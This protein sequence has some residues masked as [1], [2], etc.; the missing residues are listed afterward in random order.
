MHPVQLQVRQRPL[1]VGF[2]V[3]FSKA[4]RVVKTGDRLAPL[5]EFPEHAAAFREGFDELRIQANGGIQLVEFS[6]PIAGAPLLTPGQ[7]WLGRSEYCTRLSRL[8]VSLF[9]QET[10]EPLRFSPAEPVD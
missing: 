9:T 10:A 7:N 6:I 4:N 5:A 8:T 3:V 1:T 2:R